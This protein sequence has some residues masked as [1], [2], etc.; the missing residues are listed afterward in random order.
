VNIAGFQ[1][2]STVDWPG[3][4]SAVVFTPDC[5]MNCAYCHN[6]I[7]LDGVRSPRIAEVGVLAMLERRRG[8]LD[9][10]V[11]TGGE[12]TIQAGLESF[13]RTVRRLGFAIKLDTNGTRPEVLKRLIEQDLLDYVAMDVKAPYPLYEEVCG[14]PV[15]LDAVKASIGC[16]LE[17]SLPYEFRTTVLPYFQP[18][19]IAAIARAIRGAERYVLQQFRPD[20]EIVLRDHRLAEPPHSAEWFAARVA[21]LRCE[22][23]DVSTRGI[24]LRAANTA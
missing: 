6:R 8:F 12:P 11:L 14:G 16:L 17:G 15:E 19:H 24:D 13:I 18:E 22:L 7:L 5:T 1:R 23:S 9:G 20:K 10:L 3:C 2:L 4:V 21:E